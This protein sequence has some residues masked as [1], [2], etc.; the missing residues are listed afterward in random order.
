M[1]RVPV[2]LNESELE[3]ILA[4]FDLVRDTGE[5]LNKNDENLIDRLLSELETFDD[6]DPIP[7]SSLKKKKDV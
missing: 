5:E 7:N 3:S 1:K 4:A 6:D 2:Y